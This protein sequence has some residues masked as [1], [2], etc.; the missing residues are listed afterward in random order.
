MERNSAEESLDDL[1][2]AFLNLQNNTWSKELAQIDQL[3]PIE[4]KERL[5]R[6][7]RL[8][9]NTIELV[10][11]IK[12]HKNIKKS[13]NTFHRVECQ[14]EEQIDYCIHLEDVEKSRKSGCGRF[15]RSFKSDGIIAR[16]PMFGEFELQ[17]QLISNQIILQN[18]T[19]AAY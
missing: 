3:I 16:F 14:W 8:E 15:L 10:N 17:L 7:N 12:L 5:I 19:S 2:E 11:L 6:R 9:A 1:L 4:F 18:T 13:L